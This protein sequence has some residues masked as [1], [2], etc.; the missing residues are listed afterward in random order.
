[1]K[2]L[3]FQISMIIGLAMMPFNVSAQRFPV[4]DGVTFDW[5]YFA[6][7]HKIIMVHKFVWAKEN[8]Y[9]L[10]IGSYSDK[11][12]TE[13]IDVL[14]AQEKDDLGIRREDSRVRPAEVKYLIYHNI[15]KEKEYCG[16][17]LEECV[18]N[19]GGGQRGTM[20]Y[21]MR[22]DDDTAQIIIDLITGHSKYINNVDKYR[23]DYYEIIE[24]LGY[25][26]NDFRIV[27]TTNPLPK[28]IKYEDLKV[29]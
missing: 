14:I 19:K 6:G 9:L 18:Y 25:D 15:G 2:N 11:S 17:Y 5:A 23:N 7:M 28:P 13:V 24:S 29:D 8:Y 16:A 4:I 3:L 10:F 27:E 22:L 26:A 21:E 20:T 1:M 12:N